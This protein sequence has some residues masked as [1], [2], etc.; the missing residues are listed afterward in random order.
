MSNHTWKTWREAIGAETE[1]LVGFQRNEVSHGYAKN[2]DLKI[3]SFILDSVHIWSTQARTLIDN[4]VEILVKTYT[5]ILMIRLKY[6][7]Y[8]YCYY[9]LHFVF[10]KHLSQRH[11][12]LMLSA[13]HNNRQKQERAE[14]KAS[15]GI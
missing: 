8:H 1:I 3:W 9:Y 11:F 12:C 14:Q 6:Y 7:Y 2:I 5:T 4:S 15:V 10:L 13:V